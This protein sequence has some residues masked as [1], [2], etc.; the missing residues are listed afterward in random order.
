MLELS[1]IGFTVDTTQLEEAAKKVAALGT[2][3]QGLTATFTK[4][5][6]ESTKANKTQAEAN[7]LNAK[8][9]KESATA[10]DKLASAK[11]KTKRATEDSTDATKTSTSVLERQQAILEFM[12][13]GFSKGQASTL[14]YA[15][16]TGALTEDLKTLEGV[17]LSQR[18]LIGGDPFDK[19]LGA[20]KSLQNEY[21]VIKDVQRQFN[22]E[23]ALTQKQMQNLAMDKIRLI[24]TMDIEAKKNG[25]VHASLSE[26]KA[27]LRSLNSEYSVLAGSVNKAIASDDAI[28]KSKYDATKANEYLE[29]ELHKVRYALE[30]NNAELNRGTA[31]SLVRFENALKSSGM[32]LDQQKIKL[33][34]YRKAQVA[35]QK[36]TA[37]KNTDY[38]SRA[39]GPQITDIVVGLATG[40]APLTV[41]LQQG[42]QLRDQFA[43][44]GVAAKDMGDVMKTAMSTMAS[45]VYATGKAIGT[46]LVGGLIDMG[47]GVVNFVSKVTLLDAAGGMIRKQIINMSDDF[48]SAA[49]NVARFDSALSI[50]SKSFAILVI[51]SLA[52]LIALGVGLVQVMKENDNLAKSLALT[53]GALSISQGSAISYVKTLTEMG[54]TTGI[55]T[56]ILIEM[57]KAGNLTSESILMV[58]KSAAEMQKWAGVAIEETVKSYSKLKE[59]PVEALLEIA[60]TTGMVTPEI[61]R[62][63]IE[64]ERQGK[65]SEA[66][67]VAMKAYADVTSKQ[68]ALM[69]ETYTSFGTF[70]ITLGSSIK[71][72]FSDIFKSVM[73]AADPVK[74]AEKQLD[75]VNEKIQEVKKNLALN[76]KFGITGDTK[77]LEGLQAEADS[78]SEVIK[79]KKKSN[80]QQERNTEL[81][82]ENADVQKY[83]AGLHEKFMP[84]E[85][86]AQNEL[87]ELLGKR[88]TLLEKGHLV[89][90][91]DLKIM[92]EAIRKQREII[93]KSDKPNT[94]V[95]KDLETY[96]DVLN[97]AVGLTSNYNNELGRLQKARERGI[98]TEIQYAQ[99]VE[100][101]ITQQPFYIQQQKDINDAEEL[102]NKLLGVSVGLGKEYFSTLDKIKKLADKGLYSD[103]ELKALNEAAYQATPRFKEMQK[104]VA[105]LNTEMH[106]YFEINI[107]NTD[108]N[109]KEN[110]HLNYR[111]SLLGKTEEQQKKLRIEYEKTLKLK[112]IDA[113]LSKSIREIENNKNF[114][115]NIYKQYELITKAEEQAAEERK[116]INKGV[117]VQAAIDFANEMHN[118]SASLSDII[119]TALFEGGQ[120]GSKSLR[121]YLVKLLRNKIT[122]EIDAFINPIISGIANYIKTGGISG[123][124]GVVDK[125][126]NGASSLL[127]GMKDIG[128][129]LVKGA[130]AVSD[131]LNTAGFNSLGG[132]FESVSNAIAPFQTAINKV[133]DG[134]GYLNAAIL[135]T[136]GKW[137]AAIGAAIGTWFGGGIGS[138]IGEKIGGFVDNLFG[139]GR[140]Y[141]KGGGIEGTFSSSGFKGNGYGITREEPNQ[142]NSWFG[143]SGK[144]VKKTT[145]LSTGTSDVLSSQFLSIQNSIASFS[146]ALGVSTDTVMSYTKAMNIQ[147]LTTEQAEKMTNAQKVLANTGASSEDIAKAK[148][149]IEELSKI[150][151][152]KFAEFFGDV[153]KEM[154]ALVISP[155]FIR[156]GES[157]IDALARI[158][159]SLTVVN[160]TFDQLEV[161]LLQVSQAGG[162]TASNLID[163]FG[164]LEKFSQVTSAYY[165]NFYR[166]T[167]RSAKSLEVLN[168]KFSDLGIVMPEVNSGM[169]DWYRAEVTRVLALDQSIPANAK[170]TA[171]ILSLQDA[172][173]SLAPAFEDTSKV[174]EKVQKDVSDSNNAWAEQ[175]RKIEDEL[176]RIADER[177]G[178]QDEINQL[179]MTEIQLSDLKRA[180]LHESNRLLYD[181]L[182]GLK[183]KKKIQD[184]AKGLQDELNQLTMNEVQ[185]NELRR[186]GIADENKTLYDAVIAAKVLNAIRDEAKGIQD[187]INQLTMTE[188]QLNALKRNSLFEG[189]KVLFDQLIA[190]Q[191]KKKISEEQKGLQDEL[192]ELTLTDVQ[193]SKLKRDSLYETNR[194]LYD[195]IQAAKHVNKVTEERKS[196]ED[197][198]LQL[199]MS[200]DDLRARERRTIDSANYALF[201]MITAREKENA[202]ME[203]RKS[204]QDQ[205]DQLTMS[206]VE[207]RAR[208]RQAINESNR[209]IFDAI[210]ARQMEAAALDAA[211]AGVMASGNAE[212]ERLQKTKE[213]TDK[214]VA[215]LT[216]SINAEKKSVQ[217]RI[218]S[219]NETRTSLDGLFNSL[220]DNIKTLRGE[221]DATA[222]MLYTA[223]RA[224]ITAATSGAFGDSST[225]QAA[226]ETSKQGVS[227]A[228][229]KTKLER[230]K[231]FIILSNELEAIQKLTKPQLDYAKL[232]VDI[233]EDQLD[234]LDLQLELALKQVDTLREID[235]SIIPVQDALDQLETTIEAEGRAMRQIDIL[236]SQMV[237]AQQQY[238]Q[239]KGINT[240]VTSMSTALSSFAS[241]MSTY[242]TG[243]SAQIAGLVPT[244][245][246]VNNF[247]GPLPPPGWTPPTV[248]T[249]DSTV[250]SLAGF[251]DGGYYKGGMAMVGENGSELI[252]FNQ[253]GQVYNNQQTQK[254]LGGDNTE[255]VME[256][257]NLRQEVSLLRLEARATAV[258]T[259]KINK[260]LETVIVPTSS[261][262]AVQTTAVV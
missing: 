151:K 120:A 137:G 42:G 148:N 133:S 198:Y 21:R 238:D 48:D 38:I 124:V 259:G 214:A 154:A 184:E 109:T 224:R 55:A 111:L 60:K 251:A 53:G 178:I 195:Q 223:A 159:T 24:A 125:L 37:G 196:L 5:D 182:V 71:N 141:S 9:A 98:V 228:T 46:M 202:V 118:I 237:L 47:Q 250:I 247:V 189:N 110:D 103:A 149:E 153:S 142:W 167:E 216:R 101:L 114:K 161:G 100:D 246:V 217:D 227:G 232:T 218:T 134:L 63:V 176:K 94:K 147:T 163:A 34:E 162:N 87:N 260:S 93:S 4:L 233:L 41:M 92:D 188:T 204:L 131:W 26:V 199:V 23:S 11:S 191:Q 255:M 119:A 155:D 49:K 2:A 99:A 88:K 68:V 122:L 258:N 30:Q 205:Y 164:G 44:A 45:S 69:K 102:K 169:R 245:T 16:A 128:G 220:T 244:T 52:A 160:A 254:L 86:K 144:D 6:K 127:S 1:K 43:L 138:M 229:Y 225:L 261:G 51:S 158:A 116:L 73:L 208:E 152:E 135:A 231:A 28:V 107:K 90:P 180:T 25:Q 239:L 58:G 181:E 226:I 157:T 136:E 18:T 10:E 190:E 121:D 219:A 61:L 89:N 96:I 206:S 59:K 97:K 145:T 132:V 235:N 179:T 22:A 262:E 112:E 194:V 54:T 252:N 19:S 75:V 187:E 211:L 84:S 173:N 17:L 115:D 40:Q 123:G 113:N 50:L 15:K 139:G 200:S 129:T 242:T 66:A 234:Q 171:G 166:E 117:A 12:S 31:N 222:T 170:A 67:A 62:L 20:L 243:L 143:A 193:L 230:D 126:I 78:I 140:S 172:V 7:L 185:L 65:T 104:A 80:D 174:V 57:A 213:A 83:L 36:T 35:L 253:P 165:Q 212:I 32:T 74:V 64:L 150:A 39:V 186:Q 249:Q 79:L 156:S 183:A 215:A 146:K 105:E 203:E 70:M 56:D 29:K 82:H 106:K 27:S 76:A 14:A 3:V 130:G 13:Q 207:L 209:A 256:L 210:T 85:I 197:Q 33:D 8:A 77:L 168:G 241:T 175:A 240:G 248:P 81:N 95:D 91:D 177:K 192:N 72:F 201:D 221:V 108:V 257:K 236:K